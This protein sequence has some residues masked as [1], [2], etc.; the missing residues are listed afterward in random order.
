MLNAFVE[1]LI[2]SR[3]CQI[4]FQVASVLVEE[5]NSFL[6]RWILGFLVMRVED[7]GYSDY[8]LPMYVGSLSLSLALSLLIR[9]VFSLFFFYC[10]STVGL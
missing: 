9:F 10:I 1:H 4:L 3:I 2:C 8:F 5:Y 7:H 6:G